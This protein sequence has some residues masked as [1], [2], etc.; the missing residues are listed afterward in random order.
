MLLTD[1]K[2]RSENQLLSEKPE[3]L[4][5][6][7]LTHILNNSLKCYATNEGTNGV[8][9]KNSDATHAIMGRNLD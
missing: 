7:C 8:Q 9:D 4:A 6:L 3:H 1:T 5:I 2:R